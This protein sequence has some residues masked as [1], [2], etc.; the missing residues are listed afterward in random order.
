MFEYEATLGRV[1]DGDTIDVLIDLGFNIHTKKRVRIFGINTPESRT[2]D[3][4]EKVKGLA[5]KARLKE[6]LKADK[7]KFKLISHGVGKFGRVL[8]EIELTVGNAG[9]ILVK[10]GHAYPYFGG[11]KEEAKA[12][13]AAILAENKKVSDKAL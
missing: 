9:D 13:A 7:N 10:E 11:N 5:A 3:K 8:G 2:R 6:L 1:V 12:K 4:A